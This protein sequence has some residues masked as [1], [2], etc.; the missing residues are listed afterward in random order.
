MKKIFY[1]F[2]ITFLVLTLAGCRTKTVT[3]EPT[4]TPTPEVTETPEV[5]YLYT[6]FTG[7]EKNRLKGLINEVIPFIPN[8]EY[9]FELED[10][11]ITY[12]V[13]GRDDKALEI[14]N[15]ELLKAGYTY[16]AW[17]LT[18]GHIYEK[19]DIIVRCLLEVVEGKNVYLRGFG[20]FIV[21]KRAEKTARN[22]SKNV[23]IKIPEHFIP[24]FKPSKSFVSEVKSNVK[25]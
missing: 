18:E 13:I 8:D 16:T 24:S 14:Y 12:S 20:S 1:I 19:G 23:T 2:S 7:T 22:I 21:K 11:V 25:K 15:N 6:A 9:F 4:P 5:T 10:G 3:P 17:S